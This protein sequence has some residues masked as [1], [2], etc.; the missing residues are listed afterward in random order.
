MREIAA[1]TIEDTVYRLILE[2]SCR[3]GDDV[4]AAVCQAYESEPAPAGR[5]VLMQLLQNYDIAR[6]ERIAICQDTG[7]CVIFLEIGQEVHITGPL[8]EALNAAVR[9]AYT[10][11]YLRKSMVRD[12]LYDRVNTRDNTPAIVHTRIV[13]GDQID[14]LVT[15]KGIGSENASRIAMLTPADGEQGV[16]DFVV[17]TVRQAGPNPCPPVVVGV[18]IGGNFESAAIMAKRMTA[19]SLDEPNADPRYAALEQ[20]IL[21]QINTLGIGPAGIGGRCTALAVNI[22]TAPTHIAGMPV[23]VNLCCHAARHAHAVL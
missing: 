9:R 12:P 4:Q 5:N 7:M 21:E 13:P 20:K 6:Q 18:G 2:A 15:P 23:A 3:I 17:D 14:I 8:E 22:M 1:K 10:E 16:I 19:R 11:G